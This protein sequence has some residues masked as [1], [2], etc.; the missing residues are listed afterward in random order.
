MNCEFTKNNIVEYSKNQLNEEELTK[1]EKH[2][3]SCEDC[4][5]E[6]KRQR[7]YLDLLK[8]LDP[9]FEVPDGLLAEFSDAM[10][11]QER[12]L[13]GDER[14]NQW[15]EEKGTNLVDLNLE[16]AAYLDS[17]LHLPGTFLRMIDR[18]TGIW[19][20]RIEAQSGVHQ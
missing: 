14:W 7:K 1:Y 12:G 18:I 8:R 6:V 13:G 2:L 5:K 11:E 9:G 10:M 15:R 20:G 16:P 4:S 3:V 17:A 19:P